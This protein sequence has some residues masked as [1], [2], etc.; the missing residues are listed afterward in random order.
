MIIPFELTHGANEG[1][2]VAQ[3]STGVQ[4]LTVSPA[5]VKGKQAWDI[6]YR[7]IRGNDSQLVTR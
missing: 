2:V 1:Q 7:V 4:I 3:K 6:S 5:E